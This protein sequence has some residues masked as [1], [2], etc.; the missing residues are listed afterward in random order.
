[1]VH[2]YSPNSA[3]QQA[4]T[5]SIL[6]DLVVG[7][8]LPL[9]IIENPHFRRFLNVLDSKYTPMSRTSLTE[10]L[11]P[12]LVTKVKGDI[13][14]ALDVQ[15]N[16]AITA[17]LWSDRRLR[18]FLGVTA[19]VA[20]KDKD[21]YSLKSFLLDCRRFTGKHCGE[22]IASAFDNIV[23]EYGVGHKISYILTDNASNMKR[24]F[25]VRMPEVEQ[26]EGDS[27]DDLD[28]ETMWEDAEHVEPWSSGERLSCFAHS[29]QLVIND[30]MK[31]V[32]AI[33]RA[34]AKASKFTT[35]LHSS[36]KHRDMFEAHFGSN[37]SIPAA[38]NTRWNSTYKQ[39]KALTTLDHRSITEMCSD[40]ENLV[41]SIRE[42]AQLTDLCA[43]LEPFSEATDLTEGD[44]AVTISMVVPTILDLRTHL[45]KMEVH[46]PQ[47]VTI[48]RA[49]K[50]SL[51]KRFSGIFRRINMDEGDPEQ[52][53]NHR[54]YFLAAMLD[55]QFGLSWVDLDVQNGESGPALKRF[56]DDL[57]KSLTDLLITEVDRDATAATIAEDTEESHSDSP[58][59]LKHQRLLSRYKAFKLKRSTTQDSSIDAQISKYLDSINDIDCDALTFWSKNKE[60]FPNLHDVALK[61]LSVPAS[62]APVE[63]VFSRGGILMRPHRARLGHKMLQFLIFLKCNQ[64]LF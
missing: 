64:A 22:R 29:L 50:K 40:T 9:S 58:P 57:K 7:C 17:D 21:S 51:E 2:L 6:Q 46:L 45:I 47:I 19:H 18:S 62:S 12:H 54:I 44:T 15:S 11:I 63:R 14:K 33:A 32:K 8:C 41:F 10:K 49:M 37:K 36:S 25:K 31:E 5:Q 61:V 28:D 52:P 30:G 20:C 59:P 24:A 43:L 23:E 39:L 13:I 38:N 35:L 56:R 48:V 3:R 55:P 1:M 34:I 16:V 26:P 60:R 4:I 42:W 27:S 53:F